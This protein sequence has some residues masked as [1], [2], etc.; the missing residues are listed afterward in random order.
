MPEDTL[1]SSKAWTPGKLRRRRISPGFLVDAH[2]LMLAG[3]EYMQSSG[4]ARDIQ[5]SVCEAAGYKLRGNITIG[6]E[7]AEDRVR[8]FTRN[9]VAGYRADP[10]Q[11]GVGINSR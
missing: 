6:Y 10:A 11:G 9:I 3:F 7:D 8:A 5:A 1:R 4:L 2:I